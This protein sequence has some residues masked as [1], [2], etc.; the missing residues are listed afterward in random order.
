MVFDDKVVR[1]GECH[2]WTGAFWSNGYGRIYYEG[3]DCRAHRLSWEIANERRVP[4]DMFVLHQCDNPACVNPKHLRVGT[5][6]DNMRDR[7]RRG[8][9]P[10]GH[11]ASQS[12]LTECDVMYI[13]DDPRPASEVARDYGVTAGCVYSVRNRRT[14]KHV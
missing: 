9:H 1:E 11:Q 12:R 6:S 2:V 3:R 10:V 7:S 8:R 14:W 5:H 13:R 4:D